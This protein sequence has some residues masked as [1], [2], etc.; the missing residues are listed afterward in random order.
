MR[1]LVASTLIMACASLVTGCGALGEALVRNDLGELRTVEGA[2]FSIELPCDPAASDESEAVGGVRITGTT[3]MCEGGD[4]AYT[5]SSLKFPRGVPLDLAAGAQGT[6]AELGGTVLKNKKVRF[7][8][9]P[10]R[11]IKVEADYNGEPAL[12]FQ[13]VLLRKQ[14]L[15][16]VQVAVVGDDR[17]KAPEIYGEIL[18]SLTLD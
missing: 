8:G 14:T 2:G 7:G 1:R 13:R 11:D 3:L 9:L 16:V 4:V 5:A 15:F 17:T 10:G 12:V 18:D 6:A